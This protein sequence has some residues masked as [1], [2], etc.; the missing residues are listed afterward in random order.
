[1]SPNTHA[2]TCRRAGRP[3]MGAKAT[4]L[5]GHPQYGRCAACVRA[6]NNDT[7]SGHRDAYQCVRVH[8]SACTHASGGRGEGL[9]SL[10]HMAGVHIGWRRPAAAAA[11]RC[12]P[13]HAYNQK[14]ERPV[15]VVM[16]IT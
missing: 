6:R 15:R 11:A 13:G 7:Q 10:P 9:L 12:Q 8:V 4:T 16:A 5:P 1:M 3:E 2:H 14:P